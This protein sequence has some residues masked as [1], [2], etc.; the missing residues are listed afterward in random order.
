MGKGR[1]QTVVSHLPLPSPPPFHRLSSVTRSY[2]SSTLS[3][4]LSPSSPPSFHHLCEH[5][6]I[7][8]S[9]IFDL[10]R[11]RAAPQGSLPQPGFNQIY[12]PN[13]IDFK[14][15]CDDYSD[16]FEYFRIRIFNEYYSYHIDIIFYINIFG[17]SFVFFSGTDIFRYSFVSFFMQIYSRSNLRPKI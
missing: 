6:I 1:R 2:L 13:L 15:G 10:S 3:R 7:C 11:V 9:A 14:S 12:F 16:I 17:Y 8:L 5:I 4:S